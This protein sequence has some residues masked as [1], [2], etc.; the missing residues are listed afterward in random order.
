MYMRQKKEAM[1]KNLMATKGAAEAFLEQFH[2]IPKDMSLL[3]NFR[4]MLYEHD[5]K[6]KQRQLEQER[7]R[8]MERNRRMQ[9]NRGRGSR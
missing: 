3:K 6:Q 9:Q 1:L 4:H 5:D 7:R 8:Q 2:T